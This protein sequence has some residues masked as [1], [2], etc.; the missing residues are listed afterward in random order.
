MSTIQV[1][2][3]SALAPVTTARP[4]LPGI[5]SNHHHLAYTTHDTQATID[6]YTRV[7]GMPLVGAVVDDRIPSTGEPYPRAIA[8]KSVSKH[9]GSQIGLI[10]ASFEAFIVNSHFRRRFLSQ[11][12]ECN[13]AQDG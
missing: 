4:V 7:L 2:E 13:V 1:S 6:F 12:I 3:Q 8:L 11:E 10:P 9:E 5:P